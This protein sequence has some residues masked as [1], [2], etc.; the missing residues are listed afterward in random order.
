[1]NILSRTGVPGKIARDGAVI[2]AIACFWIVTASAGF[3]LVIGWQHPGVLQGGRLDLFVFP[4]MQWFEGLPLWSTLPWARA[5]LTLSG[6]VPSVAIVVVGG[7]LTRRSVRIKRHLTDPMLQ[8]GPLNIERG[9]T[10]NHGHAEWREMES[11]HEL[12]P[13]PDPVH[14]GIVVGEAYRVDHDNTAGPRFLPDDARTWGMG[15]KA[16]LLIDP[17]TTGAPTTMVIAGPG[18]YKS[19]SAVST[20]LHWT[21]SSV[22]LDPSTELGPMLDAALRA[23]HKEV[24]HIG[25]P[26]GEGSVAVGINVLGWIDVEDPEAEVHIRTVAGWIYDEDTAGRVSRSDDPF[27]APMGREL[28]TCLLA[29][30]VYDAPP[31]DQRLWRHLPSVW[32]L[33]RTRCWPS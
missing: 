27:F 32:R 28:V 24:V 23:Q 14:G 18:G 7:A 1:M 2:L 11:A 22:V 30:V 29:H 20:I 17:C 5:Y 4:F 25:I 9:V 12:F 31:E 10:D 19:S 33:R 21:G 3:C 8:E 26:S 6:A 16:P 15:G 13:G